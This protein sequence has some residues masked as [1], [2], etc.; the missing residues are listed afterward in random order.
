MAIRY[1]INNLI[2]S[3]VDLY[4]SS[5]DD[6]YALENLYNVRP[7]KPFRFTGIG[8][9]S[10]AIPEWIC[11]DFGTDISPDFIGIFNHNLL[12]SDVGD[13]LKLKACDAGCPGQSGACDWWSV[14][15]GGPVCE[16]SLKNRLVED[17]PN[18]CKVFNC[19][20]H[21]YW[22]LEVIDA[23]NDDGYIEIGELF[24]GNLQSFSN[25]RLQPGR[26][27][28]P[29]FFEGTQTT[30]YGQIWSNYYSE[31]EEFSIVIKN[32]NNPAQVSEMRKFLSAVK[33]AGG[34][35]VFIPDDHYKFCY[36]VYMT[37]ISGFGTQ[38][39][40]GTCGELYDWKI[41]LRTLTRGVRLLG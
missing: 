29:I 34:K 9:T 1:A 16:V 30:Y 36:Y 39:A 19:G 17:F 41:E 24:L 15:S 35:F 2:N 37:N 14:G 5:E 4:S 12:L 32:I 31:A 25:A 6:L 40:K 23:D 3:E 22:L 7:S 20:S 10:G 8:T 18:L 13:E 21:Q 26:S 27:D 28:G 33:R 38:I 11:I